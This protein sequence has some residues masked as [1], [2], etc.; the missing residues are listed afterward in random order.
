MASRYFAGSGTLTRFVLRRDRLRLA[1][2]LLGLC[3]FMVGFVPVFRDLLSGGGGNDMM[4]AMMENPAMVAIVGPVFGKANY[5]TGAMYANMML[6]FSAMIAGIMNIY[7]VARHTRADEELGRLEVIRSLPVGRLAN[8]ASALGVALL[9]DTALFLF[10]G[11]GMYLVRA[12]G[13]DLGGCLLFGA[14]VGAIGL[15]FAAAT[16]IFCQCTANNRTATGLSVLLV[17]ALYMLR[18]MGDLSTEALAYISP[19]GLVLRT[20]TFVKNLWWPIPVLLLCAAVLAALA[21]ALAQKRDLGRGLVPEKPGH[22]HAAPYLSSPFG[23]AFKLLRGQILLWAVVV[24]VL[25]AMYGSVFGDLDGFL[26]SNEMLKAIFAANPSFTLAEQFIAFLMIIMAMITAIPMLGFVGKITAEEKR[27]HT[28]HLLGRAVSRKGQMAAYALP[29][30]GMSVLLQFLAA[31]GF[32]AV[33]SM[34]LADAPGFGTFLVSA[35]SYLPALWVFW[36]LGL[37]LAAYLP[38]LAALSY[39]YLGYTFISVYL[40]TIAKFPEWMKKLTPLGYIAQY[41]VED[42]AVLPL[43]VLTGMAAVLAAL[44]FV[45]Y[46]RRDVK[47]Q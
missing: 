2:W 19:L 6:L 36:G 10:A 4:A 13:M 43:V 28:E 7:L 1:I 3:G 39:V 23:L 40:G 33:G 17:L 42:I 31:L 41:P 8:L 35:L 37:A 5:N 20:Q 44:A 30:F 26:N 22:S 45:G 14:G 46:A 24:L 34:V 32:W 25:A 27:G 11:F 16:A 18:A 47:M 21:F 38:G 15:F 9:A 29:A 12:D